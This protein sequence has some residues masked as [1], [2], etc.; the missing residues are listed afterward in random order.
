MGILYHMFRNKASIWD[1]MHS[2]MD[3]LVDSAKTQLCTFTQGKALH[4]HKIWLII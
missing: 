1:K 4:I 3:S 2:Y